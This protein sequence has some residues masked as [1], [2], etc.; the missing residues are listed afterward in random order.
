MAFEGRKTDQQEVNWKPGHHGRQTGTHPA[1]GKINVYRTQGR[2]PTMTGVDFEQGHALHIEIETAEMHKDKDHSSWYGNKKI[3]DFYM[4]EVQFA[5]FITGIGDGNGTPITLN[6]YATSDYVS[7][8]LPGKHMSTFEEYGEDA[9]LDI[10]ESVDIIRNVRR[11]AEAFMK[12]GVSPKKS[13][14]ADL[15]SRLAGAQQA[16][17]SNLPWRMEQ[18][19][20]AMQKA[21]ER[22][23]MEVIAFTDQVIRQYGLDAIQQAQLPQVDAPTAIEDKTHED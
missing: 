20:K 11:E 7:A 5:R 8:G 15:V 1:F 10:Q 2:F 4:T 6:N 12:P 16:L 18:A 19:K 13:D 23:K 3:V 14:W 21:G 9:I 22:T 17:E